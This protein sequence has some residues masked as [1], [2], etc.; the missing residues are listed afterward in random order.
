MWKKE[1]GRDDFN[2]GILRSDCIY[3]YIIIYDNYLIYM[4][5]LFS[6]FWLNE[7]K[8]KNEIC[9]IKIKSRNKLVMNVRNTEHG[10]EIWVH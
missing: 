6:R 10:C 2:A 8:I 9:M 5:I 3:I 7:D 1:W 4:K